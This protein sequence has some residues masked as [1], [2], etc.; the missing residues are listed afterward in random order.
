M[1]Q[2][3]KV[4]PRGIV[5]KWRLFML[6]NVDRLEKAQMYYIRG[7][8]LNVLSSYD[9]N[10]KEDLIRAVKL[11]PHCS[12]GWVA[13]GNCFWKNAQ[14]VKAKNCFT[15]SLLY[16]RDRKA[17]RALS[18]V[19]RQLGNTPQDKFTNIQV[20]VQYAKDAIKLDVQ[21]GESWCM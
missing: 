13:L 3:P 4:L 20:S 9:E 14:L 15:S 5:E 21:D 6:K 1:A 2:L 16:Q 10:A 11:D 18:M 19:L 17:L 12:D 8:A 7:K